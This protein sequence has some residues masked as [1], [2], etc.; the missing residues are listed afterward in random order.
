MA[1][2]IKQLPG[3]AHASE[4]AKLDDVLSGVDV[5]EYLRK[6]VHELVKEKAVA[7]IPGAHQDQPKVNL[8]SGQSDEILV[9]GDNDSAVLQSVGHDCPVISGTKTE[10]VRMDG[11]K[12]LCAKPHR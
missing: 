10:I 3:Q 12:T 5:P 11:G 1:K 9:L 2:R 7:A 6:R 4:L 8:R